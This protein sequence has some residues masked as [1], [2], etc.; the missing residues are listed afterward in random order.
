V[1]AD[2]PGLGRSALFDGRD[3]APTM[4]LDQVIAGAAAET[5]GLEPELVARTLFAGAGRRTPL[6]SIIR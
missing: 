4:G 1:L 5:F 2:W 6:T 3:L